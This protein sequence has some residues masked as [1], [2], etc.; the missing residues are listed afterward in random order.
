M[1]FILKNVLVFK[2]IFSFS[3]SKNYLFLAY[4]SALSLQISELHRAY[5]SAT[6]SYFPIYVS[7]SIDSII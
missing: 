6:S 3:P 5:R 4:S 1:W 2:I 7:Y